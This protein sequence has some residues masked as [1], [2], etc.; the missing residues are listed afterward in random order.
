VGV[1]SGAHTEEQLL[2]APHTHVLPSVAA[3]PA[4]WG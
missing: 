2:H 1:L 4:L 3:L